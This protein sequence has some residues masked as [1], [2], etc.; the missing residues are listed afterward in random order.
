MTK[1]DTTARVQAVR[2]LNAHQRWIFLVDPTTTACEVNHNTF[3][4]VVKKHTTTNTTQRMTTTTTSVTRI[5]RSTSSTLCDRSSLL[6]LA[7]TLR[8]PVTEDDNVD[9]AE[10]RQEI[11]LELPR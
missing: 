3:N 4:P 10:L 5:D 8:Y 11:V 9:V 6:S 7:S 1:A 2:A